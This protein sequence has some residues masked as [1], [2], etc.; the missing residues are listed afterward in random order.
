MSNVGEAIVAV[1]LLFIVFALPL[2]LIAWVIVTL[3]TAPLGWVLVSVVAGAACGTIG[4]GIGR[5]ARP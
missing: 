1:A 5:Y 2:V 4:Y 3:L